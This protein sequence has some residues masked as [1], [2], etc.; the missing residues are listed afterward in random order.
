MVKKLLES[1][2]VD[3]SKPVI[4]EKYDRVSKLHTFNNDM[5]L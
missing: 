4:V 3:D 5:T 2:K 1:L